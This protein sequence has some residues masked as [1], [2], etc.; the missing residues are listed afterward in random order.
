[1]RFYKKIILIFTLLFISACATYEAQYEIN[2]KQENF[3]QD[4]TIAHSFYLIG[5][6]GNSPIG[7]QSEAIKDFKTELEKASKNSTAI[8]LGDNIYPVGLPKKGENGRAFAEHQ[9]NTQAGA[10]KN[11]KGEAIFIPGNH[12]WYSNGLKGLKRQEKYIEN[13]LGKNSFLPENGC[14]IEKINIS[15]DIVLIIIDTQWYITDWDKHPNLNDDCEFKTRARFIDEYESLIKK[16]RGKTTIVAMHH[17]MYT[18]GPHGGQFDFKSNMLP[19]PG[20]GTLK[21]VIRKTGGVSNTDQQNLRYRELKDRIVTLS[22]E[23]EKVIFVSGHEHSLQF[24]KEDNLHQ[25]ISGAGSKTTATRNVGGGIF[26]YGAPGYSIIDVFKDGSSTVRFYS[27]KDDKIIFKSEVLEADDLKL[28][29]NYNKNDDKSTIASVYTNEETTKSNF[30]KSLWGER[31]RKYFSTKVKAP[32]VN[33]DTLFGGLI[34]IR[35]GGGHQS[36]SLRME[37]KQG[38]EYIMRALKKN[39]VQ[40]I[41]AVVFTEQYVTPEFENTGTENLLMDAFTASHPYVPFT[42]ATLSKAVD[43]YYTSP[44][45]YYVPKQEALGKFNT[46]FGNELYMIE[47]RTGDGH[48][49]KESFGFSNKLISTYDM[50]EKIRKNENHIVDEPHY[51]RA[52]LFDMLIG[53]WDRHED[54]WRWA[55]FK[56]D[57]KTIYRAIPRDRDQAFSLMDDGALMKFGTFIIPPIRLLRSYEAHLKDPKWFNLEPFPLDVALITNSGKAVWDEQIEF[58]QNNLTDQVIDEAFLHF[59]EEVRDETITILKKKLQGRRANLKTMANDYFK[60]VNKYATIRGTDK[61]D[62]FEIERLPNGITSVKV[63]RIIKGEKEELF[64][65][66]IYKP[67]ETKEIWVFGLDDDDY[68][69]VKGDATSKIKL[70]I[71]GGQN[72]DTYNIV[73]GNKIHVYDYKSKASKTEANK[74]KFHFSD[75]YFTNIYDYKKIKYNSRTIVPVIGFNPDDGFKLGLGGL[76]I[77]NGF[78]GEN[79][80][81]QHKLSG[82]LFF[83]TNGFSLDYNGEF[84]NVCKNVNLGVQSYFTS[85]NY[86]INFFGYGNSTLNLN[87]DP[88]PGE[89]EQTLDYNRVRKSSFLLSPSLIKNGEYGSK[90]SFGINYETV[91]IENTEGRFLDDYFQTDEEFERQHFVGAEI[92]YGFKNK[93][94]IAFPTLGLDFLLN[95]GYKNNVDNSNN[96][97]YLIPSLAIDYKLVP[98]GQLVLATKAKSHLIFGDDFEFYQAATIGASDGLRGYRNQRFTGK[99]SF[100][101]ITDLRYSFKQFKTSVLPIEFGVYGG[102]DYGRVWVSDDLVS[103]ITFNKDKLNTS[104]GGGLFLN[105]ADMLTANISLFNSNDGLRFAFAF[106]FGF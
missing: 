3:P 66:R 10:V 6:G 88:N 28:D 61:D 63:F 11:Y 35:K 18:N 93:D 73:N 15:E 26:S 49:D 34:P 8:F 77:K 4:K 46:E 79:F 39:A 72:K 106:G 100:Y 103:D 99:S 42:I 5:D 22:Q 64:R 36:K 14:P 71:S 2:D 95:F 19:L 65:E 57:E 7:E 12:D 40:Y 96:F 101:Q 92:S 41:Q 21:N 102:F 91:E 97:S 32:N 27:S 87:T 69:E 45:L 68:F 56:E 25:I 23:N 59:P 47:E 84:E 90:L 52:R 44:K 54:Q 85:H 98:N 70:R 86:A 74:G 82:F 76:F 30:Y 78:V 16:A 37:D 33:L 62:Y 89:E 55:V 58:L 13:I 48:G 43:V 81:S 94:Y 75:E 38:R 24:L 51:I 83:A 1:M 80:V 50:L 9:L 105:M 67:N 31:Y 20:I 29:I 17:P 104:I 60:I 53:D